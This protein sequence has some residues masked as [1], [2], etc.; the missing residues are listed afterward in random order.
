MSALGR[1][2]RWG[3]LTLIGLGL[4]ALVIFPTKYAVPLLKA[5][6]FEK[7]Q[8]EHLYRYVLVLWGQGL[9]CN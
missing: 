1:S 7:S 5:F 2:F 3:N 4:K 9:Q 6:G 8:T